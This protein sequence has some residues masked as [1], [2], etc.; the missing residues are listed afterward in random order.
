M[1]IRCYIILMGMSIPYELGGRTQQKARTRNA[2]ITAARQLLAK[3]VTP[4][5]E[6]TADQAGISRTTAF[7]YFPNQR[8]L[9]IATYPQLAER[10]LLGASAPADPMARLEAVAERFTSQILVY[11]PELRAQLRL[12]LEPGPRQA[13]DLP[14]RQ[15]RGIG[16]IEEALSPLR[17][18]IP[19]GEL[20]RLVLAIRA[21]LGI[22]SMV[23]L[24]DVAGVS[25]EQAIDIMRSS[26]RTLL[27]SAI[28]DA[29]APSPSDRRRLRD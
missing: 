29:N 10:S 22:E 3:G 8:A 23:W 7:R 20:H 15:G 16:W 14:L 27:R 4:T 11:E 25:R 24:T 18:R 1:S 9:L 2:L 12:A 28:A 17:K 19:E 26:A 6:K 13:D 21:T 5:V